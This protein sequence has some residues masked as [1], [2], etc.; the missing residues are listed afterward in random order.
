MIW[1]V[2]LIWLL[3]ASM[4][5]A[6]IVPHHLVASP[7]ADSANGFTATS[8][9]DPHSGQLLIATDISGVTVSNR[10]DAFLRQVETDLI[11]IGSSTAVWPKKYAYPATLQA[12]ASGVAVNYVDEVHNV[13]SVS[14]PRGRHQFTAGGLDVELR[15]WHQ[16][17]VD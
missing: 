3:G 2:F 12:I 10:F 11:P 6:G 1:R 14:P 17:L 16:P 5:T 15:Q 4:A 9:Y 13:T 8:G 7:G